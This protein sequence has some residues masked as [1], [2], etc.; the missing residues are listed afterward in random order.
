MTHLSFPIACFPS[1]KNFLIG[2]SKDMVY[3]KLYFSTLLQ[4]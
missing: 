2:Y 1:Q 3:K 4:S